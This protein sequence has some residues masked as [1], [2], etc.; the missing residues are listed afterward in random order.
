M[1][2]VAWILQTY[3]TYDV[4]DATA[5]NE[6]FVLMYVVG[7]GLLAYHAFMLRDLPFILVNMA[8]MLFTGTEFVMLQYVKRVHGDEPGDD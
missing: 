6:Y 1:L 3:H 8:M 5:V 4:Q 2:P 7:S